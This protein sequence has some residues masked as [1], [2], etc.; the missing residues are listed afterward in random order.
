[1]S[2]RASR[3]RGREV[4]AAGVSEESRTDVA[5]P[6]LDSTAAITSCLSCREILQLFWDAHYYVMGMAER[7]SREG[8][9][10]GVYLTTPKDFVDPRAR[11]AADRVAERNGG[12]YVD[13]V[14]AVTLIEWS[15]ARQ[16]HPEQA[17]E[18]VKHLRTLAPL[19][20]IPVVVVRNGCV[21]TRRVRLYSDT[22]FPAD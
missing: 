22:V 8:R 6:S 14:W 18:V 11:L 16:T 7:A 19:G 10:W 5:K 15:K 3:A 13:S 4:K 17:A 1:M 20:Q 12:Y 9:T 2:A 21:M